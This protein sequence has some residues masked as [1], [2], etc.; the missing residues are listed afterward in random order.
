MEV[1]ARATVLGL[2][3]KTRASWAADKTSRSRVCCNLAR[4]SCPLR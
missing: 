1:D 3:F 2:T 4:K